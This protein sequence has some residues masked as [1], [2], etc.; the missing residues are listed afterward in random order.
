MKV[1]VRL[2][3]LFLA[4]VTM[5]SGTSGVSAQ[6]TTGT[7]FG[8]VTDVTGAAIPNATMTLTETRTAVKRTTVSDG[9]GEYTY[10][11]LN[12][13]DY[14]VTAAVSG[15]KTTTQTG[16]ALAANQNIRVAFTLVAGNVSEAVEVEAGVTLVDTREAQIGETI[17]QNKIENLPTRNR[18]VYSLVTTTPGVTNYNADS[19]IGTRAGVAFSVNGLSTD[20]VSYYLDGSY[21]TITAS[22]SG[23]NKIPNPDALSEFRVLTSNF[24][25]EF[26]RS[27]AAVINAITRSGTDRFHGAAY[28]FIRN[29]ILNARGYFEQPTSPTNPAVQFQQNQFGARIGG[30]VK[31]LPQTFFFIDYQGSVIRQQEVINAGMVQTLTAAERTGDF[32]GDTLIFGKTGTFQVPKLPAGTNCGTTAAPKICP[33]ALDPVAQNLLKIVPVGAP[34]GSPQ[35]VHTIGQQVGKADSISNE[36]LVRFDFNHFKKHAIETM[37]FYTKGNDTD[38]SAGSNQL[39]GYGGSTD[40][41]QQFNVVAADIWT[42]SDRTVNSFRTFISRNHYTIY[43][44]YNQSAQSLGSQM[45][46]AGDV[47]APSQFN[48]NSYV[49]IGGGAHGPANVDQVSYGGIDTVNL[50]RGTH[51]IK[52]GGSYVYDTFFN[53]L[54]KSSGGNFAFTGSTTSNTFADF[55]LGKANSLTQANVVIHDTYSYDPA[56]YIQDD[57]QFT[58]R[59][60]LNLG[61]R[62]EVFPPFLGDNTLGTFAAG[63]RSTVIPSAPIGL[64]Y[65]G[66]K[67]IPRGIFSTSYRDFAPRVGFA[68]DAFGN[69]KTSLRGGLGVFFFKQNSGNSAG[70]VQAPYNLNLV[71]SQTANLVCPYGVNAASLTGT[72][73]PANTLFGVGKGYGDP[74]P[75]DPAHP[76]FNNVAA[77]QTIFAVPADG[78]ATP[79]VYE[80][81]LTVEQ[82]LT[83]RFAMH[84]AYVGNALRKNYLTVDENAPVYAPNATI[85]TA[86]LIA[87]RPYEPYGV[88][89]AS[90]FRFGAIQFTEPSENGNYNSLQAT[91]RGRFGR[92]LSMFASYVWSKSLNYAG[93]NV[94]NYDIRMNY[95]AAPTDL[96]NRFVASYLFEL[97]TTT[98]LGFFGREVLNGWH[99]NGITSLQSG[100]P[101]TVTSGVDTNR[102][103][104]TNDRVNIIGNPSLPHLSRAQRI[105]QGTLNPA[106]FSTPGFTLPTDNPYGDE[107]NNQF[108]GPGNVDTDLSIFKEF[109]LVEQARFQFRAEAFNAFGNVNLNNPRATL[110]NIQ[111]PGL[112]QITGAGPARVLQFGAKVLF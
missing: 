73:C 64:L 89:A 56:L 92:K 17:D 107:Q 63:V 22:S 61:L 42:L 18:D 2:T 1:P 109:A 11:I 41:A 19:N 91:L 67:N 26:G 57:W 66:D 95:G 44:L 24:D 102:D 52:L 75:Y 108:Y 40:T 37:L 100:S 48:L 36:G 68:L 32:S 47:S 43:N 28:D 96:R 45:V 76:N 8:V 58:R 27:P 101:F 39:F 77:G 53:N 60:N 71:T 6:S 21:D 104:T 85:S 16:I 74:Y 55:L 82:Q 14:I 4:V 3:F 80:Y 54:G 35:G 10:A 49:N 98:R 97:P 112:A 46:P 29:N 23:G 5:L 72:G 59:L 88:G 38:P 86:G 99:L 12:P 93:P 25:A 87:R 65:Q 69:G 106:A 111:T 50:T 94:N 79:Y 105:Q 7:I 110:P 9:K 70:Q 15:F 31:L 83:P 103:G 51:S 90:T 81:N 84:V 78:G 13:G 62:W 34:V 30:P 20:Q 33:A